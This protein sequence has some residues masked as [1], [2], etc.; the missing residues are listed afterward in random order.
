[1]ANYYNDQNFQE[2]LE[3][4][5]EL[6]AKLEDDQIDSDDES[7]NEIKELYELHSEFSS[8]EE[9]ER[10]L[11]P[12]DVYFYQLPHNPTST[13]TNRMYD[14]PN[15]AKASPIIQLSSNDSLPHNEAAASLYDN[16]DTSQ[17]EA[18]YISK[19]NQL[20]ER[21]QRLDIFQQEQDKKMSVLRHTNKKLEEEKETLIYSLEQQQNRCIELMNKLKKHE[22]VKDTVHQLEGEREDL[23]VQLNSARS[24]IQ[25]LNKELSDLKQT[26]SIQRLRLSYENALV[27]L[28][29]EYEDKL[30]NLTEELSIA[31]NELDKIKHQYEKC[32]SSTDISHRSMSVG[33]LTDFNNDDIERDKRQ[34]IAQVE[35]LTSQLSSVNEKLILS[36]QSSIK[37]QDL[38]DE[39]KIERMK[40]IDQYKQRIDILQSD[41]DMHQAKADNQL[42]TSLEQCR[43]A[44]LK[45]HEDSNKRLKEELLKEKNEQEQRY[46]IDMNKLR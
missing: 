13:R 1:M 8:G 18:L 17:V 45:L 20:K 9:E 29:K 16:L 28:E 35:D 34:L 19:C 6:V 25:S 30:N 11:H 40:E 3:L 5:R 33:T 37:S 23:L 15:I 7:D 42:K 39:F 27:K 21:E 41:L 24:T 14:T 26:D 38:L 4:N 2:N 44:C 12:N 22:A 36:E 46:R 10:S 31:R 43:L 32:T